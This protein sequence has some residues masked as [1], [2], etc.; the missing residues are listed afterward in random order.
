[1]ALNSLL[2]TGLLLSILT[3]FLTKIN[4]KLGSY[5]TIF[6]TLFVLVFLFGYMNDVGT[7]FNLWSFGG[8][9]LQLV[10]SNYGWFFSIIM[11]LTY[12][13]VSFFNP[14][15]IEKMVNPASY[16][17]LYVFSVVSTLGVFF[18]KDFLTLF[19]FWEMVVW[20]S[21]FII[22]LG[23][24]RKA[25]VVYYAI[26]TIGSFSMFF[27]V[28]YLYSLYQTFDI[29]SISQNL[30]SSPNTA[31]MAYFVIIIA[32]LAKLGIFPFHT[33]LPIAHGNAPHTF[34]PVLSGGLVKMGAFIALLVSAIIPTSQI[35]SNHIHI[36]GVPYEN[37]IIMVLGAI[38]IIVGTL[39]AIK[40]EDAK[41]LIAYS[42]VANG[43]Y[44]LIGISLLDQVGFAGGMMHIFNHAMASAAMFLTIGAVAYRTGTTNMSEL[45]GLI[46]KMPVTFAAYLVAI[47]SIAGIP[48]TSGFASKWLIFQGLASKGLMFI[49]FATF[50]GSIGSFMYVFRP[51][52]TVFLGQLSPKHNDVKEVP[53]MMQIPMLVMSLLTIYF[54]VFPSHMLGFISKIQASLNLVPI[55]VEGS[56]IYSFSGMWDSLVI[57]AVFV[58]GFII[59]A[60]IFYTHKKAQPVDQMN[61]YTAG[62][63]IYDPESYHYAK[64]YYAPF[65]RLYKNHPSVEKFYDAIALRV[66]EFGRLVRSWFFS[67]NASVGV[68]WISVIITIAFFWG[69][70]I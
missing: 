29:E 15:W 8:F 28:M 60:L 39:M 17:M 22:P 62:E 57:T 6:S 24:S 25:S 58:I 18:A 67:S 30:I 20:S 2:I 3:F 65:E 63:F 68:F 53:F 34:S 12:F 11:V 37:Y 38:S 31:V 49:A 61:T 33:W 35:F 70:K 47:I 4:K 50:F 1:M 16:N 41:R 51:L 27:A 23:K 14:Y 44:I 59:A 54:G 55:S 19:I 9:S 64:N 5:F 26:S 52:A 36:I 43:G 45:G 69:D 32:G 7:V 66:N 40:Q 56:K 46:K 42:T 10:S 13:L 21:L 48:P